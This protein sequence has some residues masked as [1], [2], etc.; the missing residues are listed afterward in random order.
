MT[1]KHSLL[2]LFIITPFLGLGQE[3]NY[4]FNNFGKYV[5]DKHSTGG[6]GDKISFILSIAL[7]MS[8]HLKSSLV[9]N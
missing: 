8:W 3:G 7:L 2:I 6:I 4:K 5:A 9:V 1:P